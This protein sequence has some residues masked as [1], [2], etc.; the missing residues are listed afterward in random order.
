MPWR[1]VQGD[2]PVRSQFQILITFSIFNV[3]TKFKH[4]VAQKG[5]KIFSN[6]NGKELCKSAVAS[7]RS[8]AIVV[9]KM[10]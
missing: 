4:S 7:P 5:W 2:P 9:I 1:Y 10:S 6:I 3:L 8:S